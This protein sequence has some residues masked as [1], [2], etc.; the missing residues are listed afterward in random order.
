MLDTGM[1][2]K[3]LSRCQFVVLFYRAGGHLDG[4]PIYPTIAGQKGLELR[5]V[6]GNGV[7][8]RI[9]GWVTPDTVL[10]VRTYSSP[11]LPGAWKGVGDEVL[12]SVKL[13]GGQVD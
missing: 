13:T 2:L 6:L 1:R 8:E 9:D 5:V 7:V 3:S 4:K 11:S 10:V 12:K